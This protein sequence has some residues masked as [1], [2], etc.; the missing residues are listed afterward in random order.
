MDPISG[1]GPDNRHLPGEESGR[2]APPARSEVSCP[3]C[4]A[5]GASDWQSPRGIAMRMLLVGPLCVLLLTHFSVH[6]QSVSGND[7]HEMCSSS[8]SGGCAWYIIGAAEQMLRRPDVYAICP[9]NEVRRSQAID[10]VRKQLQENPQWR[11]Q[12]AS[13]TVWSA[14]F[15]AW[16]CVAPAQPPSSSD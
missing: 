2:L 16:P 1:Y 5:Q 4:V 8:D 7:L 6:A 14:L 12:R 9:P 13:A 10:L 11:H 15:F 3:S